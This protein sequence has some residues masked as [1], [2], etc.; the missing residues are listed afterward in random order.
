M[1][2]IFLH[3]FTVQYINRSVVNVKVLKSENVVMVLVL[4]TAQL[5]LRNGQE[6]GTRFHCAISSR[7]VVLWSEL[8]RRSEKRFG[9]R[10]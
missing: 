8:I 9:E 2:R 4:K 3:H 7:D 10:V 5:L 1:K 6:T